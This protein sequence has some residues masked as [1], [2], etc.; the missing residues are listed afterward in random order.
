LLLG[1]VERISAALTDTLDGKEKVERNFTGSHIG[2][3]MC[4]CVCAQFSDFRCS[5]CVWGGR[6]KW[7]THIRNTWEETWQ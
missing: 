4:T 3:A 7:Y 6:G 1:S 5:P 2:A